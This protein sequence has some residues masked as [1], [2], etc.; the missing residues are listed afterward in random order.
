[1]TY[2]EYG[3]IG[4]YTIELCMKIFVRHRFFFFGE[5]ASWNWFDSFLVFTS[6]IG[7]VVSS[8]SFDPA[9]MRALRILK[10]GKAMRMFRLLSVFMELKLLIKSITGTI[11][12]LLWS[13]LLMLIV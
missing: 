6:L 3:F 9:F 1:M 10:L 11:P 2:C 7:L 4:W 13:L 5:E 12:A 8:D